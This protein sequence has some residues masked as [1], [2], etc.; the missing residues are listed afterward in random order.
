MTLTS[1]DDTSSN[2]ANNAANLSTDEEK[3]QAILAAEAS[4]RGSQVSNPSQ[5]VTENGSGLVSPHSESSSALPPS[6]Q[7]ETE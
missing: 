4:P 5:G 2:A 7:I 1:V 6:I 3:V